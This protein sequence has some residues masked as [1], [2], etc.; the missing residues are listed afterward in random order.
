MK[1]ARDARSRRGHGRRALTPVSVAVLQGRAVSMSPKPPHVP[2]AGRAGDLSVPEPVRLTLRL[3]H[4]GALSW[5]L[6][7]GPRSPGLCGAPRAGRW[8]FLSAHKFVPKAHCHDGLVL[9]P[10]DPGHASEVGACCRRGPGPSW[11]WRGSGCRHRAAGATQGGGGPAGSPGGS[12]GGPGKAGQG[13]AQPGGF[14][15]GPTLH[16]PAVTG[17]VLELSAGV[18]LPVC[19][20]GPLARGAMQTDQCGGQCHPRRLHSGR[21]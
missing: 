19:P 15:P 8:G 11:V 2:R 6:L 12:P 7:S 3:S 20:P 10:S 17:W 21:R 13:W 4:Q 18:A 14:G 5:P 1:P 16:A 9:E